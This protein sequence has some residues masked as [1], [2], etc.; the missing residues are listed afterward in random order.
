MSRIRILAALAVAALLAV[1]VAAP[2]GRAAPNKG[3]GVSDGP[4]EA[5][6]PRLVTVKAV[7]GRV[8]DVLGQIFD[9]GGVRYSLDPGVDGTVTVNLVDVP[10][11]AALK[12]TLQASSLL[13]KVEGGVH[14]V[15]PAPK[16]TPEK[17]IDYLGLA[18][19]A[20]GD[21][22][23]HFWVGD[24]RT[25]RIQDTFCGRPVKPGEL[26]VPWER[27]TLLRVLANLHETTRDLRLRQRIASDWGYYKER[28][29]P[30]MRRACVEGSPNPALDDAGWVTLQYLDVYRV[31]RDRAA[32]E[33]AKGLFVNAHHRFSDGKFGGGLRYSD[34]DEYRSLYQTALVL[35]GMKIWRHTREQWY[36]DR[37]LALYE[38]CEKHLLR[39]DGLYWCT[40]RADGPEDFPGPSEEARN[41]DT[42]LGGNM[43]M[44]VLHSM[45]YEETRSPVYLDRALRTADAITAHESDGKGCLLDDRDAWAN[46]TFMGEWVRHVLTLKECRAENRE[47]LKR[48]AVAICERARTPKGFYGGS[49]NGPAEGPGSP[50]WRPNGP[51]TGVERCCPEQIMTCANAVNVIVAAADLARRG[52]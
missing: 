5:H 34:R 49:W 39:E 30:T 18:V 41:V 47:I 4:A 25:G 16:V 27:G 19:G 22:L 29:S 11:D 8:R 15:T 42:F 50:W 1:L 31:T 40:Y 35:A 26:G 9:Q 33:D 45:L 43:A 37:S 7:G 51:G 21:L 44:G 46:G 52:L 32:L 6:A 10:F 48:T 12:T 28:F 24:S 23:Q 38:W 36:R 14:R 17:E 20:V 13:C 2:A 3:P